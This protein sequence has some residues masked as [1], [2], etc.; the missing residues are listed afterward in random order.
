M[1]RAGRADMLSLPQLDLPAS[2]PAQ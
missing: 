2:Q 1:R